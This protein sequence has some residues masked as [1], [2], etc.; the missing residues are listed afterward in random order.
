MT[1]GGEAAS[2]SVG[3]EAALSAAEVAGVVDIVNQ[4]QIKPGKTRPNQE[5]AKDIGGAFDRDVYLTHMEIAV[6]VADGRATLSGTVGSPYQRQRA[7]ALAW[8]T[9]N[10]VEVNNQLVI[11]NLLGRGERISAEEL[12][13]SDLADNVMAALDHDS[14]IHAT[15]IKA[16]A[17][18]GHVVLRG[19]VDTVAE[20]QVAEMDARDVVGAVWVTNLLSVRTELRDDQQL[21][22][23][24]TVALGSDTVTRAYRISARSI[25]GVVTLS[26]TVD[27]LYPKFHASHL[28]GRI[29]GVRFVKNEV[30]VQPTAHVRDKTLEDLLAIRLRS[31]WETGQ[32]FNR[33]RTQVLSGRVVLVGDVDTFAQRREAGRIAALMT[34]VVSVE[35][36]ITVKGVNYPWDDWNEKPESGK[37][38]DGWRYRGDFFE[39]PGVWRG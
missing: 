9:A 37:S 1:L 15:N 14:R 4:I 28:A 22:R 18:K 34:G 33:L 31:N 8:R 30:V 23:E 19:H 2:H 11:N 27:G 39:R 38:T 3:L 7:G 25:D 26:G 36:R 16:T 10:V 35:N 20:R 17:A 24:L 21:N 32:V 5:I 13:D 12:P 29:P 6:A